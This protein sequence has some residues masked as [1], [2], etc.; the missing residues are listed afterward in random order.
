VRSGIG[1]R[2]VR[3]LTIRKDFLFKF[4][5][6]AEYGFAFL[7]GEDRIVTFEVF[8]HTDELL[9]FGPNSRSHALHGIIA[10]PKMML[11]KARGGGL[12]AVIFSHEIAYVAL[13]HHTC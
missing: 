5:G 9:D 13:P 4:F 8:T 11:V 12:P 3:S 1:Y 10:I 2:A 6:T 7:D